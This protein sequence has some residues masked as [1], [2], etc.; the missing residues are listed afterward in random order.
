MPF[1]A[2]QREEECMRNWFRRVYY[3]KGKF[4]ADPWE[5]TIL[6]SVGH[7]LV[8]AMTR[9]YHSWPDI[10]RTHRTKK[11]VFIS[12]LN[13]KDRELF[14]ET[15]PGKGISHLR[16]KDE[17]QQMKMDARTRCKKRMRNII[18]VL[19]KRCYCGDAYSKYVWFLAGRN[20][21]DI[22]DPD[23][24]YVSDDEFSDHD[25]PDE[26][27]HDEDIDDEDVADEAVA[28]Q[29]VADQAVPDEAIDA[30]AR[31]MASQAV[32]SPRARIPRWYEL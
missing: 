24:T 31:N 10:T 16:Q 20:P 18:D 15:S 4:Q 25:F 9:E 3:G 6:G 27:D 19:G 8:T 11:D 23:D 32:I 5:K 30:L 17:Q 1:F 22:Y 12:Y 21:E 7:V 14:L 29:A 28:D 2:D 26:D 13:E